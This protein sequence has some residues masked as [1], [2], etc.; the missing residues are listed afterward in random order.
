M[1]R[2]TPNPDG[3]CPIVE[4]N[5]K[6]VFLRNHFSYNHGII[7]LSMITIFL[8]YTECITFLERFMQESIKKLYYYEPLKP[9]I[10]A[11]TVITNDEEYG[12]FIFHAYGTDEDDDGD[13]SCID[14][15]ENEDEIDNLI[16]VDVD[17]NEDIVTM[18]W[19]KGDDFQNKLYGEEE[20]GN[21][22][23]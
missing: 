9:L 13:D 19:T 23:T 14:G 10:S 16:D 8:T 2:W 5:F 12:G 6:D 17:F 1:S 20:G 3:L 15:G 21:D 22:N 18:N 11:I 4:L 7:S